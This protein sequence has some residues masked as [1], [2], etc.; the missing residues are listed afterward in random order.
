[1][2]RTLEVSDERFEF[3]GLRFVTVKSPSLGQ[4][5]DLT[6]FVPPQAQ[7]RGQV[8]V[9]ILL[10]GIYG[11]HWAWA[12]KGGAHRTAA[13]MITAGELPPMV[14]AMPSDGL[15]GEGSG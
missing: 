4:R 6:L 10:H 14:L 15:W 12:L 5:A 13:R 7:G 2:F 11:S 1:M 3:D 9:V 8:P